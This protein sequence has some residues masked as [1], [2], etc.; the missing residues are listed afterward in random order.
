MSTIDERIIRLILENQEFQQAVGSTLGSLDKLSKELKLEGASQGLDNVSAASERSR[1][2][3]GRFTKELKLDGATTGLDR[4]ETATERTRDSLGRFSKA[5]DLEGGTEGLEK[6]EDEVKKTS[7]EPLSNGVQ[8][9]A[10]KFKAMSIVGVTAIATVANRAVSA[11]LQMAKSLSIAPIMD[12][13]HEYETNLNSIQT[14][15]ANTG[16]EG[17]KGLDKVNAALNELNHYSDQTIYNFT[18][19]AKNIGT[20]T[21]A[22]VNLKTSTAAIKG[23]A[24][25]AAIS[26]SNSEQASAAMYQLSQALAAGKVSLEDWNSVVNAGMGGKVFQDALIETARIHGVKIDEMIKKE[27]SFRMTLQDGWLTSKILTE[28]LAK[29]TGDLSEQQLKS[30]GY[31][32]KQIADIIKMGKTAQDAATKVKTMS[33][34]IDTL[35]EAVG[36]GWTQTWQILFGNFNE[37]RDLFTNVSNVLGGFVTSSANA[38]N[39]VLKDWKALGGRTVLI[40]AI[41]KAFNALIAVIKPI[42]DAF[43]EIF[44][45]TT[46]KQLYEMTVTFRDFIEKLKIGDQTADKLKRTFAGVFAV[47]G[48]VWD[49]IKAGAKIFFDFFGKVVQG[50]GGILDF[51]ARIG[52]F[53]VAIHDAIERGDAFT[54]FFQRIAELVAIPIKLFKTLAD[55]VGAFFDKFDSKKATNAVVGTT[56]KMKPLSR[57]IDAVVKGGDKLNDLFDSF[58]T[59]MTDIAK[60]VV[61][62]FRDAATFITNYLQGI[63]F[64]KALGAVNTGLFA[65]LLLLLKKFIDN[66]RGGD[67]EGG[68]RGIINGISET[69][70]ELTGTLKTMQTTLKA[71]TLLEIAA[72]IGILTIS[73]IALSKIDSDG[74]KRA[75]SA[76]AIMF[77][78]LFGSMA[79]FQKVAGGS[80][81]AQLLLVTGAMIALAIAIDLLT[82]AIK[83]LSKLSAKELEKGL[84]SIFIILAE[85]SAAVKL[86]SGAKGMIATGLGLIAIAAGINLLVIAVKGLSG[87]S[88]KELEKGL[89]GV[90]GLL[91]SLGIFTRLVAVNKAGILQGAGILLLAVAINILA[92]SLKEFSKFSKKEIE[93]GLITLA[94]SLLAIA[95]AL[96]LIPPSSVLSAVGVAIVAASL[97][98]I[99]DAIK[100][101]GNIKG[102]QIEKGLIA[103]AGALTIIGIALGALPASSVLSSVA[104]LI[105]AA[106]LEI[107]A[108]VLKDMAKMSWKEIGKSL[109]ELAGALGI[110]AI[111]VLAM[112][113]AL[114][115]AVALVVVSGALLLLLPVLEAF[116]NMSL[117][118]IGKSLL[119][120]AGVFLV[121]G[122]AAVVLAPLTPILLALG[123]AITLLGVGVLAAGAGI[124]LFATGL[125]ALAAAGAAGTAAL[126]GIVKAM[127][128]LLPEVATAIAEAIV[129]FAKAISV[130]G[131]AIVSA[132]VV[133]LDSLITA[134]VKLIPKITDALFRLLSSLI[135][136]M[137]K[138]VPHMVESGGKL[139]AG[140]LNGFAN[141]MDKIVRA[142]S[143]VIISF[144]N[145]L[146]KNLPRIVD[147]AVRMIIK[148]V[149]SLSDAIDDHSAEMG[150]AGGR[151]AAAIVE[152]MVKG[153]AA[154]I[155]TVASKAADLGKSAINGAKGIL[156][157][158]SPSKDFIAIGGGTA[159]GFALG[160]DKLGHLV[161]T[162]VRRMGVA[163]INKLKD[164]MSSLGDLMRIDVDAMPTI[165]PVLDLSSVKRDASQIGSMLSPKPLSVTTSYADSQAASVGYSDNHEEKQQPPTIDSRQTVFNQYNNSPK[166]LSA[167]TIYRNTKNQLSMAKEALTTP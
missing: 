64:D 18:E 144:L 5:L 108:D 148:F 7:F 130:A 145:G 157:I 60:K 31:S 93:K 124:L 88:W 80:G 154:G 65:G 33:Q 84:G 92:K 96:K 132:I 38:R 126:V 13:Y 101:I 2:S 29:F 26:G 59:H 82:I 120:L 77:A 112:T 160:V 72:A 161:L 79:I 27:G 105:A 156:H 48:I 104:I 136:T 16:L 97:E 73:A 121:L 106:S 15:L 125:T 54:K 129:A 17:K 62:F 25:L 35:K 56:E 150:A 127:L 113:E 22:G 123:V 107:I 102:K 142:G 158:N 103:I 166:A 39:K 151:L 87:L 19:M 119:E 11:G 71:T 44:P 43:R 10:N 41:G 155:S 70:E 131:P 51:T 75:L 47:L 133:V 118:E 128:G 109:V 14:I 114:P 36:S 63:N 134:I 61:K 57:A 117:S 85:L 159:E 58:L 110:I 34:L 83:G 165:T 28:T 55:H 137:V 68:L 98:I 116:G 32:K 12:G 149:N 167:A 6:V 122:L 49:L 143:N 100:K 42:R 141:S 111:A 69:F 163:S 89:L 40:D 24:N 37:A 94:G 78:Q 138:Y 74:L 53:L 50:S 8:E 21:A 9:V 153:L 30:M 45:K 162:A 66:F 67:G 95:A 1:D 81:F 76:M 115:G 152:G 146:S 99:A 90:G 20:F 139:I 147:A 52:D 140:I 91:V 23:I 86:M 135:D 46:G 4:V 164:T 3:L